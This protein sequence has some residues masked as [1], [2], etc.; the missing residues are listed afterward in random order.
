[1]RCL[2]ASCA[3]ILII[4]FAPPLFANNIIEDNLRGHI[5]VLASDPFEGRAPGTE[6]EAKTIKYISESWKAAGLKPAAK[7]GGWYQPV[8]LISRGQ[9]TASYAF[10]I[11]ERTLR[12][13]S[14]DIVLIGKDSRYSKK[15]LPLLFGGYGIKADGRAIDNV[16]GKAV[17]ILLDEPEFAP[18]DKQ[19]PRERRDML[20]AAGAEAV[21]MVADTPANW[22]AARRQLLSRP[23]SLAAS[24]KRAALEGVMSS[25]FAVAL[26]TAAGRDWDKLRQAAKTDSFAGEP[27]GIEGTFDVTTEVRRFDSYN[28][29]GKLAGK[30]KNSG[31]VMYMGHWDHLGFCGPEDAGDRIC[32][33]AVDNASGIAVLNEVA[34]SL[35]K[36]RHDRDIFFVATTAEESGLLGAYAFAESPALPLK[37]IVVALNVDMMAVAPS[38]ARVAITGRDT[39]KLDPVV[40]DVARKLGRKME[41]SNDA[42]AF[43]Q[44]QDGWALTQK[45]VP[46]LMVGGSFAD[47]TLL[48][49]FLSSDYHSVDDELTDMT[50]LSGAADDVIL[51]VELGRHFASARKYKWKKAGE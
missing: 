6:G 28:V 37:Q 24:D 7:D 50:D 31:A 22:S 51:H 39:T 40:E 14:D 1:M 36:Q 26:V 18:T 38:G 33:G 8:A 41:P 15:A 46:S 48:Q 47:M 3:P 29:V 4:A 45:G 49:K 21:I 5:A 44:R 11:N 9:G 43:I 2:V 12:M 32:N 23:I 17:L 35:G 34:K 27:L 30:K 19:S 10:A 42:N 25:E 20:A 13:V 16:A